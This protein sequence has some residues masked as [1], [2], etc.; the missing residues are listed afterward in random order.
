M[1]PRKAI[2]LYEGVLHEWPRDLARDRGVHQAR[3]A[4]A[5]AA[6][7]ERDRAEVEGRKALAIAR[8]TKSSLVARELK[9]LGKALSAN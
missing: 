3:L 2:P 8:A 4:L 1:R 9:Q 7:G 6:A 5:C